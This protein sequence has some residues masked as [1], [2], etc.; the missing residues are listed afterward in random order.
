MRKLIFEEWLSLD[1][2]AADENGGLSFMDSLKLN[3]H[4]DQE[5]LEFLNE[6]DTILLGANTYRIFVDFWPTATNDQEIVAD[7]INSIPKMI[8]SKSMHQAP[9]GKWPD[10]GIVPTDAVEALKEMKS[11]DG[12]NLVLWGSI[13]IAQAF[14][15]ENLIDEYFLRICPVVL[16]AGRP[17]FENTGKINLKLFDTKAYPSGLVMLKYRPAQP[18]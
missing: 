15:R 12:Q 11:Q 3:K 2:F 9:W 18:V 14:M 13:S 16:G 5:Q 7:K 1:G 10:A 4:S 6:I 17:L 8:F